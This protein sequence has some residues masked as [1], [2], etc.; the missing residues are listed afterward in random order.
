MRPTSGVGS[1]HVEHFASFALTGMLYYLSYAHNLFTRLAA[2]ILFAGGLEVLQL[3]VPG[4][5]ARLADFVMD[6]LGACTGIVF[7]FAVV[8]TFGSIWTRDR[9]AGGRE[10]RD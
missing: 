1:H 4:R 5:H 10:R 6:A 8:Q 3:F 9:W 2:A 7:G